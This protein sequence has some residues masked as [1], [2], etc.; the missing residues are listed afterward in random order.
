MKNKNYDEIFN[1]V[2]GHYTKIFIISIFISIFLSVPVFFLLKFLSFNNHY[3]TVW[4]YFSGITSFLFFFVSSFIFLRKPVENNDANGLN[5]LKRNFLNSISVL[6]SFQSKVVEFIGKVSEVNALSNRHIKNTIKETE[7]AAFSVIES[8]QSI[9]SA[10]SELMDTVKDT[11]KESE[12]F[13]KKMKHILSNNDKVLK[14]LNDYMKMRLDDIEKDKDIALF[15][16][17]NTGTI[18]D[19]TVLIEEIADQ[20]NLLALNA[21]IEAAR[22]GE[23]GRGFAVVADE[24]RR[25]SQKSEDAASK[26]SRGISDITEIISEK[27]KKKLENELSFSNEEILKEID[28]HLEALF[29]SYNL[30]DNLKNEIIEKISS[31]SEIV[32]EK[33]IDLLSKVQFQDIVRQQ[34]ETIIKI[35]DDINDNINHAANIDLDD[36]GDALK[37]I[38]Y[39]DNFNIKNIQKKYIMKQQGIVHNKMINGDLDEENPKSTGEIAGDNLIFF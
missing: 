16:Q 7:N 9:D 32:N 26:I 33:V 1:K 4:Y 34:L 14:D 36:S 12:N 17:N 10:M 29:K 24:V 20:T 38:E 6:K 18:R 25:L 15:L 8:T 11:K 37:K 5:H 23:H 39:F 28:L 35:N 3:S 27:F 2:D 13:S 21:A 22:A 19:L 30:I 31:H